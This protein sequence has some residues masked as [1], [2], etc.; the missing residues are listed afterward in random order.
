[1]SSELEPKGLHEPEAQGPL[2]KWICI[3]CGFI[4]DEEKGAPDEG[5]LPG[6]RWK[7]V[8]DTWVCPDCGVGKEEFEMSEIVSG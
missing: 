5:L 8:P 6:T 4:Y 3:I 2:K 1:M 7:D